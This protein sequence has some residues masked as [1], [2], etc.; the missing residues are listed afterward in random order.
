MT[1]ENYIDKASYWFTEAVDWVSL[2]VLQ[3]ERLLE[4]AVVIAAVLFSMFSCRWVHG[5]I[6][7]VAG[8]HPFFQKTGQRYILSIMTG[9]M[10]VFLV[11]TAEFIWPG[12]SFLLKTAASLMTAWVVIR[13]VTG[14]VA[15][16][17]IARFIAIVAWTIAAANIVGLLTP[18]MAVLESA[19]L[20]LGDSQISVLDILK[21]LLT[22]AALMWGAMAFAAFIERRLKKVKSVPPSVMVLISKSSRI[23]FIGLAFFIA[24]N[25]TGVDL[26]AFAVFGGALGVG[27]G[28]GLQKVVGNFIS[29]LILV[30]DRS[31]KPG[32]VIQMG[33]TYG[34]ISKMAARYTSVITR[35]GTEYLI[36]NESLITEPVVNWTHTDKLVRR[37]IPVQVS[38]ESNVKEAMD[39]MR[40]CADKVERVLKHPMPVTLLKGFNSDGVDL[41]LRIWISD[42]QNGVANVCSEV[43]VDIWDSF[44]E[45]NIEFPFPQRVVHFKNADIEKLKQSS[46]P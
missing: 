17:E 3:T 43:M 4:I 19:V 36:P 39:I 20:P 15:D 14:V 5:R 7:L 38:Y 9:V 24:L 29:G 34:T 44:H 12:E 33:E 6:M 41:E 13:L 28:F 1:T 30:M 2:N 40:G 16:R 18:F 23:I 27:I 46:K 26:T 42:P 22:F 10:A 21:G 45:H 31:I 37:K 11:W 8:E 25:S 35:D 32:D